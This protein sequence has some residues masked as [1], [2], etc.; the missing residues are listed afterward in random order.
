MAAGIRDLDSAAPSRLSRLLAAGLARR[1]TRPV[2]TAALLPIAALRALRGRLFLQRP[3][4][5]LDTLS[6]LIAATGVPR[7][8]LAKIDVEGAEEQVIAGVA[9]ADWPRI[10]QLVV[11]VH[12]VD[13]RLA[14]LTRRLEDAGFAVTHAREDWAMHD[15]LGIWTLYARR[16]DA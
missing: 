2:I 10:R 5:Q 14:R 9:D 11:E 7:V 6:S 16:H 8:D 13:G 4:C 3:R 15:M 12:D 1:A